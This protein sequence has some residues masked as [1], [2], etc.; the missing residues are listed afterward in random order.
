MKKILL[1]IALV[2]VAA[3]LLAAGSSSSFSGSFSWGG[4][5]SG[6]ASSSD[7]SGASVTLSGRSG[8]A[9]L[10]GDVVDIEHGKVSV[11]GVPYGV[12]TGTEAVVY[13]VN[14]DGKLLTIAGQP[15][16]PLR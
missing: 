4:S 14:A 13:T 5:A 1:P 16:S 3:T 15:A 7:A 12:V 2:S 10:A 11:N 9:V 8:H 6:S